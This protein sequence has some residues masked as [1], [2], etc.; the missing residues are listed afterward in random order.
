MPFTPFM[1]REAE[2]WKGQAPACCLG[3]SAEVWVQMS[4]RRSTAPALPAVCIL[5]READA[6]VKAA[7]RR[8]PHG[9]RHLREMF[10]LA[11][12]TG[13]SCCALVLRSSFWSPPVQI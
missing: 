12:S 6:G 7:C 3:G 4:T 13:G 10:R 5:A 1:P 8:G 2:G 9:Q 11:K